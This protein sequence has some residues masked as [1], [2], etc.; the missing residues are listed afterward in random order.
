MDEPFL[1]V[2]IWDFVYAVIGHWI[3]WVTGFVLV[4]E[5]AIEF[6][7]QGLFKRI[8]AKYPKERRRHILLTICA[9]GF[10][11]ASFEAFDERTL[12]LRKLETQALTNSRQ[13]IHVK[14]GEDFED[15]D[16]QIN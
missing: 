8:D 5:Q 13:I 15:M 6:F 9:L 7:C 10:I 14:S 2:R 16:R 3:A 11:V 4:I 1:L 12:Q